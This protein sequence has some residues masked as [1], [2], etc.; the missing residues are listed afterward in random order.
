MT[1]TQRNE[2]PLDEM[3]CMVQR[4]VDQLHIVIIA[5][6]LKGH[7]CAFFVG[8]MK[9]SQEL[10]KEKLYKLVYKKSFNVIQE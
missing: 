3:G 10:T 1:T 7:F 8:E 2:G 6:E 5:T 4:H 9:S